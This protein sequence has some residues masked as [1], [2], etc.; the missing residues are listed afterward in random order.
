MSHRPRSAED[1][2]EEQPLPARGRSGV[3]SDPETKG[4]IVRGLRVI[5]QE[6][7]P[8]RR[9]R[10]LARDRIRGA[11]GKVLVDGQLP[12]EEEQ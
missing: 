6:P 4:R 3:E 10:A 12:P 8:E 7:D 1:E 5:A 9:Q 11:L 2:D